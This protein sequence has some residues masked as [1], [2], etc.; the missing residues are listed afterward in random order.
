MQIKT[1][2]VQAVTIDGVKFSYTLRPNSPRLKALTLPEGAENFRI[3]YSTIRPADI[4]TPY[5]TMVHNKIQFQAVEKQNNR[6]SSILV[7]HCTN[8]KL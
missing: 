7:S 5:D 8:L 1:N 6:F 2:D 3:S 4:S